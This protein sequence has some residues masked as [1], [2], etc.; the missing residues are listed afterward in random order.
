MN[1]DFQN[2]SSELLEIYSKKLKVK[3]CPHCKSKR[4]IK[5]SRYKYTQRFKCLD[6]GRTFLPSTG[7]SLHYL[8]KKEVF[9]EYSKIIREQGLLSLKKMRELCNIS[10]LTAFD[11]RHKIL[12]SIPESNRKL[13]GDIFCDDIWFVYSQKGRK[14]IPGARRRPLPEPFKH[15][16]FTVRMISMNNHSRN[17]MKIVKVGDLYFKDFFEAFANSIDRNA[18][19]Y[20]ISKND[21]LKKFAKEKAVKHIIPSIEEAKNNYKLFQTRSEIK[22]FINK[23][24]KGVS[25]KYLQLYAGYYSYAKNQVFDAISEKF[26]NHRHVWFTYTRLEDIYY[27]FTKLATKV[28]FAHENKRFWKSTRNMVIPERSMILKIDEDLYKY[29]SGISRIY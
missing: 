14:L 1:K 26:L 28:L 27:I 6:C 5:H 8:H 13:K 22:N 15:R 12:L 2:I 9:I 18:F 7:T 25:T 21:Q 19:I 11:W 20:N 23:I 4:F 29:I 24:L 16:E 10:H 17:L 3:S